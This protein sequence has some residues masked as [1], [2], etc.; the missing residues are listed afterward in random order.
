MDPLIRKLV[1]LASRPLTA[2]AC[3]FDGTELDLHFH[4]G[5]SCP[6]CGHEF[7]LGRGDQLLPSDRSIEDEAARWPDTIPTHFAAEGWS[8]LEDEEEWKPTIPTL[9][10]MVAIEKLHRPVD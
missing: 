9:E 10:E 5:A 4:G 8:T 2:P 1:F 6:H 3:P 7:E